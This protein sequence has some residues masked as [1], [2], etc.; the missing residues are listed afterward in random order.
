MK[1]DGLTVKSLMEQT[2]VSKGTLSEM[3]SGQRLTVSLDTAAAV[4]AYARIPAWAWAQRTIRPIATHA[5]RHANWRK[6]LASKR[7]VALLTR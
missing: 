1:H 2:G 4:M 6:L 5:R 3:H 7:E